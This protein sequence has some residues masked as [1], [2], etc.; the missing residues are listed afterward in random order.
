M[1]LAASSLS[2][3]THTGSLLH[4]VESFIEGHGFS[5]YGEC[6]LLSTWAQ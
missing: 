1:Y 6:G 4:H 2:R 5:S 3:S